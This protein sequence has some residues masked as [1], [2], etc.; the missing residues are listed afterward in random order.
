MSRL[1]VEGRKITLDVGVCKP[2]QTAIEV[3]VGLAPSD[4]ACNTIS[5]LPQGRAIGS[6][7]LS[8]AFI[9]AKRDKRGENPCSSILIH[10]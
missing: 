8:P 9:P 2:H 5:S 3:G 6:R 4:W 10:K 7:G 1:V